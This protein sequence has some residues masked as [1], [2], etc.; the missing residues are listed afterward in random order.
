[1]VSMEKQ[2]FFISISADKI[3][4]GRQGTAEN[5]ACLGILSLNSH[6]QHQSLEHAGAMALCWERGD[7]QMDGSGQRGLQMK[8]YRWSLLRI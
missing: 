1:M 7:Q 3:G 2:E 4:R 6:S 5:K 8:I